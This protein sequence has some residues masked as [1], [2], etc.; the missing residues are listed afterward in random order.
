MPTRSP[1][2]GWTT[3]EVLR[4]FADR[5]CT[6]TVKGED[7]RPRPSY[8]SPQP[9]SR[10]PS[11]QTSTS[12]SV[13]ALRRGRGE[14]RRVLLPARGASPHDGRPGILSDWTSVGSRGRVRDTRGC[15]PGGGQLLGVQPGRATQRKLDRGFRPGVQWRAFGVGRVLGRKPERVRPWDSGRG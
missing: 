6:S 4:G 2:T 11:L 5:D 15:K 1:S 9:P 10:L 13:P 7:A 14:L 12:V 3:A 8:P